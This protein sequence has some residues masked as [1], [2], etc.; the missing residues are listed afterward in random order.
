MEEI[1]EL[2]LKHEIYCFFYYTGHGVIKVPVDAK[3][4]PILAEEEETCA[5]CLKLSTEVEY[6]YYPL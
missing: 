4:K 6:G 5:V 3:G 1:R 2:D